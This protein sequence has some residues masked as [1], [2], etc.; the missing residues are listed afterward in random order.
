MNH[1]DQERDAAHNGESV[2]ESCKWS[3][4]EKGHRD[5]EELVSCQRAYPEDSVGFRIRECSGIQKCSGKH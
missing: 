3:H 5:S 2:C 1:E 4:V